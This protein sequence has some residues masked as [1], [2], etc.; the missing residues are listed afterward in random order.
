[1]SKLKIP[2]SSLL[3]TPLTQSEM[4]EIL[5]GA[6]YYQ[7]CSCKYYYNDGTSDLEKVNLIEN[8]KCSEA[9]N[10]RCNTPRCTSYEYFFSEGS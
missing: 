1:M 6:N 3:G 8:Q 5:G 2:A 9:C 4:K 10:S 7:T